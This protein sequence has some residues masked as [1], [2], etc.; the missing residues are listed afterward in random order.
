[1][2]KLS[3]KEKGRIEFKKMT[4]LIFI[5]GLSFSFTG[6]YRYF[7]T[8]PNLMKNTK[9]QEPIMFDGS[10][11]IFLGILMIF[12]VLYRIKCAQKS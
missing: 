11:F 8:N 2:K 1:M 12:L 10:Y 7:F 3:K 9:T 4:W 5:L 6:F